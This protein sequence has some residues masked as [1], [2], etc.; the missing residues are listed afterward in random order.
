MSYN[1]NTISVETGDDNIAILTVNRPEKLNALNREV[2]DELSSAIENINSDIDISVI[3]VTGAGEKAFVAGADIKELS[4]LDEESGK[5]L[6]S[7]GQNIFSA[8]ENSEK[9]YIAA[10]N[11]YALG[12]GAELAM[13]CHIR[14]GSNN[15]VI[16]LPETSLG[17]IPGYGGTQRLT[18][19][20][21]R[22][23]ALEM[24][25]TAS[26]VKADEAL[27]IG[28]LNR[29]T[30]EQS[31]VEDARKLASKMLKNGP[32]ALGNAIIAVNSAYDDEGYQSEASLFG[33]LCS[34]HDFREGTTAFL[35]K[36][37]PEFR[38][39]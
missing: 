37:K 2:L 33:K 3:I 26:H 27:R 17:I 39:A 24:I 23:K 1:Y 12:G 5:Q 20:V 36:R 18:R 32:L 4:E 25:L 11:G 34:T 8:I 7:K 31:P 35:E 19:L 38:G 29:L 6:S 16:G 14:V 30:E 22:A 13:A 28:L 9:P 15:A 10:I 21:G